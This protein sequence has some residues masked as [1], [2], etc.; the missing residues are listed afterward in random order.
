MDRILV[1]MIERPEFVE[2]LLDRILYEWN[3]PIIDQQLAIGV[4]G[5][6]F[7]EDWGSET[8]LIFS[9]RLWRRF[10]KPRLALMYERCRK[11]GAIVGQHSDGAVGGLFPDLVEIGLQLFNP[12]STTIMD[13]SEY[14]AAWGDKLTFY[15]GIDVERLMPFGTPGE[16]RAELRRMAALMGKGG[17][18]ILQ[19]SHTVLDDVPTENLVA[20]VEEVRE[21]AGLG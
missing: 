5:F 1:D 15:G 4:D 19:T 14:K 10:I 20:Y 13:P 8:A 3:L 9:P 6:Y 21:M 17:G 2:A 12:L 18:Y 7:A 11:A 16:I